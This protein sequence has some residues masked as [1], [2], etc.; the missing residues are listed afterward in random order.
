MPVELTDD[1]K[2]LIKWFVQETGAG[3][4]AQEFHVV[5]T[6]GGEGALSKTDFMGN[7]YP[8]VTKLTL[9]AL[10]KAGLLTCTPN[11]KR[12]KTSAKKYRKPMYHHRETHRRCV[13]TRKAYE[14]AIS[15]FDLPDDQDE[16]SRQE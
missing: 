8:S 4:L 13:L 2:E 16:S 5:W 10:Q 6:F 9:D 11:I 1:E 14:A 15:N 12:T 3:R 7:D